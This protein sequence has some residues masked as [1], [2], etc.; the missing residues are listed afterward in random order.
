MATEV[1]NHPE[2]AASL[3]SGIASDFQDLIKQQLRLT[4]QE[5]EADLHKSKEIASLLAL[6]WGLCSLGAF[7]SCLMLGHLFHSLGGAPDS[8]SLPLWASFGLVACLFFLGG[9][10]TILAGKKKMDAA[11]TPLQDTERGLKE[12]LEWKTKASPS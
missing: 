1:Q 8:S 11:G 9:G 3:M 7:A 12:N 2:S 6:G 10:L 5:I 4:R